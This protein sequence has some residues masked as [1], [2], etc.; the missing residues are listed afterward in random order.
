M[1]SRGKLLVQMVLDQVEKDKVREAT[2][3]DDYYENVNKDTS[4]NGDQKMFK[5]PVTMSTW[6]LSNEQSMEGASLEQVKLKTPDEMVQAMEKEVLAKNKEQS[7]AL[8]LPNIY[9]E[10]KMLTENLKLNSDWNEKRI[11]TPENE[12]KTS[13]KFLGES[14]TNM[15]PNSN[16]AQSAYSDSLSSSS[17]STSSNSSSTSES[18]DEGM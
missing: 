18:S 4:K 7:S 8:E 1:T 13:D 9:Q 6:Q 17:G 12:A 2:E 11:E 15:T 10:Q 14:L 5:E 16:E 3:H